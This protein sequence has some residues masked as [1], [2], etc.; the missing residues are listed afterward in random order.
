MKIAD[1]VATGNPN[2]FG[3]TWNTVAMADGGYNVRICA[4]DNALNV[5]CSADV[6]V[7]IDNTPAAPIALARGWNLVSLPVT[8]YDSKIA[9]VLGG[10]TP[11]GCVKQVRTWVWES[12]KLVEKVW[13][14][15]PK[16]LTTMVDG[17]GYWVET[18]AAGCTLSVKGVAAGVPPAPPVSYKVYTGWN[19]IGFTSLVDKPWN[20]YLGS[21]GASASALYGYNAGTGAYVPLFG[22]V[23]NL[24]VGQGYWLAMSANS[25]IYP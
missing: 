25:T 19:M 10:V 6:A 13:S 9:S 11:A 2:E 22:G 15:G 5:I 20:T 18:T 7:T 21:A 23:A 8:P 4:R 3:A 12:G 14:A 1:G 24:V 16:T 17:Q